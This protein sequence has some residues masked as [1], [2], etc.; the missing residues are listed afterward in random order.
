M[1]GGTM[2]DVR[3]DPASR[4]I[5]PFVD[6]PPLVGRQRTVHLVVLGVILLLGV[7][8]GGYWVVTTQVW[9]P[10][11]EVQHYGYVES[12][13]RGDGIPTVGVD[14]LSDEAMYSVKSSPTS[15]YLVDPYQGNNDDPNWGATRHQYE[16]IHGPT[17]YVLMT[18]FYWLGRPWGVTGSLM[19]IRMGTVLVALAAVPLTWALARRL[20]PDRAAV[21]LLGPALLVVWNGLNFGTVTNDAL[22][23]P[24]AAASGL[25][26]LRALARPERWVQAALAGALVSLTMV[27][28]S[29]SLVLF[30]LVALLVLWW[31]VVSRPPLRHVMRVAVAFVAGGHRGRCTVVRVELLVLS[32]SQRVR[33]R[34]GAHR[35]SPSTGRALHR[36]RPSPPAAP[37]G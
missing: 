20:F 3:A 4:A 21:W 27:T 6:P 17:Y 2:A 5:A 23:L 33:R 12:L 25:Q 34:R 18:P 37:L 29:T 15:G 19:A 26:A 31:F 13:A 10:V 28:K 16:G 35:R 9:S 14:L 24:L 22:V 36:R 30:S 7:L 11:D 8:K 32:L 1:A